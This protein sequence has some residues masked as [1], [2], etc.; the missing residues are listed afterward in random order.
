MADHIK[1][2]V[3]ARP[4][5][6]ESRTGYTYFQ[7]ARK[8]PGVL[9]GLVR[10]LE[11]FNPALKNYLKVEEA[12]EDQDL[13]DQARKDFIEGKEP[14]NTAVAYVSSYHK[15]SAA[16]KLAEFRGELEMLE[17]QNAE[18]TQEEYQ[19]ATQKTLQKYT[20]GTSPVFTEFF[21]GPA[22]AEMGASFVRYKKTQAKLFK[23]QMDSNATSIIRAEISEVGNDPKAV[24]QMVSSLRARYRE[25]KFNPMEVSAKALA[26]TG[27]QAELLGRPDLLEW[28]FEKDTAGIRLVDTNLQPQALASYKRAITAQ[29]QQVRDKERV[30]AEQVKMNTKLATN[31]LLQSMH[32][33]DP[34]DLQG[35]RKLDMIVNSLA[36]GENEW[37]ITLESS[38]LN[39]LKTGIKSLKSEE[40]FR[41]Y[42]IPEQYKDAYIKI[43]EGS[44]TVEDLAVAERTLDRGDYRNILNMYAQQLQKEAT[45]EVGADDNIT[46]ALL[47]TT[48]KEANKS[49]IMGVMD[50]TNGFNRERF[51]KFH[52]AQ[53]KRQY[54]PKDGEDFLTT[55]HTK[56]IDLKD[57]AF[58]TYPEAVSIDLGK[59]NTKAGN[60]K[61]GSDDF[62]SR[63]DSLAGVPKP[64]KKE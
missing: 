43:A 49:N 3:A 62:Y 27:E 14:S 5:G 31:S 35:M 64:K 61:I 30:G 13:G 53:W 44:F 57:K 24:R 32:D 39:T 45:G 63:L 34:R 55:V 11:K 37:G 52:F 21:S 18:T 36:T 46:K 1:K 48:L 2:E 6:G 50:Q 29:D 17:E 25:L 8:N 40:G 9:Q 38:H 12:L 58:E 59:T 51:V 19:E 54:K 60:L 16:S 42:S 4:T 15:L 23:D 20:Q 47:A 10:G 22:E 7:R 33:L 26:I 28:I 56:L 41:A